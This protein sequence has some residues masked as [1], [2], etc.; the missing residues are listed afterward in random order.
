MRLSQTINLLALALLVTGCG[1]GVER[2]IKA[3][4]EI[5]AFNLDV[6]WRAK[7]ESTEG[8]INGFAKPGARADLDPA[9]QVA[10][11]KEL[12]AN[13]IQSFALSCNGYS[14]YRG[15]SIPEQPGLKH[16]Y[17]T[18]MVRLGHEEGMLVVGYFCVGSN[19]KWGLDHPDQSYGTPALPHIPF[20]LDYI[21][22]LCRAI[23]EALT[24]TKMDGFMI[25]WFWN[26]NVKLGPRVPTPQKWLACEQQMYEELMGESFPGKDNVSDEVLLEYNRRAID[27][28]WQAIKAT[29]NR[30][31][32]EAIIWLSCSMLD[33]PEMLDHPLIKEVDWLQNEAGDEAS[34]SAIKPYLGEHTRLITT[35]SNVF[36]KRHNLIGEEVAKYA[37]ANNIGIYCYAAP[38]RYDELFKPVS[39]YKETPLD[40]FEN[41]NDRNIGILAR[42]FNGLPLE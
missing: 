32:P 19:T 30:V 5:R 39:Y 18:D 16:D 8:H 35:F 17:L 9:L 14:W 10:W 12:G 40:E 38:E 1:G 23:E 26:P 6:N 25:D 4:E 37:L 24:I 3:P 27:R 15:S 41:L 13:V 22:Y 36:F 33:H 34:L 20:T 28:C 29:R 31:N 21:E 7:K 11:C 42:V 2:T